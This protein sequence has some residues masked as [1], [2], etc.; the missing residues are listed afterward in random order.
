MEMAEYLPLLKPV[1]S[2]PKQTHSSSASEPETANETEESDTNNSAKKKK[3]TRK[4]TSS[5]GA[6]KILKKVKP[7]KFFLKEHDAPDAVI[8]FLSLSSI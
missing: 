1:R 6:A 3:K 5:K 7:E 4:K 2:E 8:L